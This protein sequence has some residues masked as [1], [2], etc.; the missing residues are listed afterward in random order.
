MYEALLP[1][2]A[3]EGDP[4]ER[5][6]GPALGKAFPASCAT[7]IFSGRTAND[8][9]PWVSF[10]P[11]VLQMLHDAVR[12]AELHFQGP[13]ADYA[14]IVRELRLLN[15]FYGT[16]AGEHAGGS[17]DSDAPQDAEGEERFVLARKV[18]R[19]LLSN[20]LSDGLVS[21]TRSATRV[22]G[23][24]N[25]N[26]LSSFCDTIVSHSYEDGDTLCLKLD[27]YRP[28]CQGFLSDIERLDDRDFE[29]LH[30][31][32]VIQFTY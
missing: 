23:S 27:M 2:A 10:R 13:G 25:M 20:K 30:P 8:R 26:L 5:K 14:G 28:S 18:G 1:E 9:L 22:V 29:D 16:A 11:E 3:T 15:P 4:A 21:M 17:T 31:E 12:G 19:F 32:L 6:S 24:S 7:G